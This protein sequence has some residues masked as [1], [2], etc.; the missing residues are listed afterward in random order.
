MS[1]VISN[2]LFKSLFYYRNKA[3]DQPNEDTHLIYI[4]KTT[5]EPRSKKKNFKWRFV[6]WIKTDNNLH[7]PC[8]GVR[9]VNLHT[10]GSTPVS[11]V[12][13]SLLLR[14]LV[15]QI[16]TCKVK[17]VIWVFDISSCPCGQ[18]ICNMAATEIGRKSGQIFLLTRPAPPVLCPGGS[19]NVFSDTLD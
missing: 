17:E 18:W 4:Q 3:I 12:T 2:A 9:L 6:E 8:S 7:R 19:T 5:E 15:L 1:T 10:H 13:L 14:L 16:S 11:F